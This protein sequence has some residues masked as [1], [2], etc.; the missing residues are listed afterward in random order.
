MHLYSSMVLYNRLK[1]SLEPE[2][3]LDFQEELRLYQAA[4]APGASPSNKASQG[5]AANQE[6]LKRIDA[7]F[8]RY[9]EVSRLAYPMIIPPLPGQ[10]RQAWCNIGTN[11]LESLRSGQLH[12]ADSLYAAIAAAYRNHK[13]AEFNQAVAQYR[14]WAQEN[15]LYPALQKGAREFFFN[16]IEPFYKSMVIYVAALL[17]GC[18]F[19]INLSE[20][21]ASHRVGAA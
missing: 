3:A 1:N 14:V 8:D 20:P 7:F 5:K 4:L 11:L 18:V 16:Q 6:D 9:N 19:W 13:P 2:G 17:L 15:D 21:L 12:P 10:P